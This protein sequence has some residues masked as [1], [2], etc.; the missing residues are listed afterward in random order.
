MERT[1]ISVADTAATLGISRGT[2]YNLINRGQLHVAKVG[3]RTV[4]STAS[5]RALVGQAA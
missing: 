4:V 5:I 1:T 2:V 3:R